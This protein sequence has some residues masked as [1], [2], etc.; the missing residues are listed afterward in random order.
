M[1]K[2]S[3]ILVIQSL[4]DLS[5]NEFYGD[6]YGKDEARILSV[7]SILKKSIEVCY[8]ISNAKRGN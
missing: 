5:D 6:D 1:L 8:L 4:I 2:T 7:S 3:P